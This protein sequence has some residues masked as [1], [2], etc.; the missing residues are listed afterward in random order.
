MRTVRC[1]VVVKK[2]VSFLLFF[3]SVVA[4]GA[5]FGV[6]CSLIAT[7]DA[8]VGRQTGGPETALVG[9][10]VENGSSVCRLRFGSGLGCTRLGL[11]QFHW[12]LYGLK[13]IR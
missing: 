8:V 2:F 6:T 4:V 1:F 7:V 3:W 11:V 10:S 5:S 9:L 12:N 13:E